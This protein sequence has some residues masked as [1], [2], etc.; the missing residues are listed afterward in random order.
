MRNRL[1]VCGGRWLVLA[2]LL[3]AGFNW[4]LA[5]V[6]SGSAGASGAAGNG[7]TAE[8][9][10][11]S[12]I[13]A[14]NLSYI[15]YLPAGYDPA[16]QT[17]YPVIYLLHGRG[18]SMKE[19]LKI[20][21]DLDQMI[22]ARQIPPLIAI[23]PD[24]PSSNR[25]GYYID[26]RFTGAGK[27]PPGERVETAFTTDLISHVDARYRTLAGRAGR[28]LAGFSMGGYGAMRFAL[29]HSDLF[30]A[31]I[32]LSPAVYHPLP[33]PDSST[34][35]FG[36]FGNG[37]LIF[38]ENIYAQNNYPATLPLFEAQGLPLVMFIAAGDDEG[39]ATNP[40]E[41]SHEIDY[42]A[43]TL[44]NKIRRVKNI[45]SQFRVV[46]GG[47][48]WDTWQPTFIEGARYIFK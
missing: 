33:A 43:H 20:K 38:D 31:A 18:G 32:V 11:Y 14:K 13:L 28:V 4:T 26:S 5:Q 41:A 1:V 34:R 46:N 48:N 40:A 19:W 3:S 16:G 17:R 15:V 22:S 21:P 6:A 7:T 39:L 9:D 2:A 29:A 36:A 23:L 37:S 44:Y 35:E 45:S 30:R 47:H 8:V 25:A 24:A 12:P 10:F 42:E 27:L